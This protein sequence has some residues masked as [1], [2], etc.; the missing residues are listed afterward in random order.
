MP[1]LV[2][3]EA[4][5]YGGRCREAAI[6]ISQNGALSPCKRCGKP[7]YYVVS[8]H[9]PRMDETHNY[10]VERVSR[11]YKPEVAEDEGY[12]PMV[13]SMRHRT[14]GHLVIWPFYWI[15]DKKEKWR[16]GQF[17]PILKLEEYKKAIQ[18]L[19]IPP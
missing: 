13:F 17:P 11:I 15:K 6:E 5:H 9:Y 10:V 18:K 4:G 19:A 14:L 2:T 7:R 16:V 12:D 8:Q 3:C 1:S